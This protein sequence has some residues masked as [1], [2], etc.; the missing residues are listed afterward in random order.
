MGKVNSDEQICSESLFFSP[1]FSNS[2]HTGS[3]FVPVRLLIDQDE[4]LRRVVDPNRRDRW[5]SIDPQDVYDETPLLSI[6]HPN[7]LSL[8]VSNLSPK[9][10]AEAIMNHIEGLMV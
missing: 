8:N 9:D 7:L 3:I 2:L 10:A 1:I 5:K 4:H 6:S